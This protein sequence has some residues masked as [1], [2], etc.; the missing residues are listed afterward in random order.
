MTTIQYP[1]VYLQEIAFRSHPID[2]VS[3]S[4]EPL[5]GGVKLQEVPSG[6]HPIDGVPTP[7]QP[8]AP[9]WTDPAQHD[10]G[11]TLVQL[12]AYLGDSLLYR[13]NLVPERDRHAFHALI[14]HAPQDGRSEAVIRRKP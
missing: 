1:G 4:T 5:T 2:G 3:T 10:P 6:V 14:E 12:F 13:S 8:H 7:P 11:I 9:D